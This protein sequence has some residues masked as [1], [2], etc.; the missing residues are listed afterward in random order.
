MP[1]IRKWSIVGLAKNKKLKQMTQHEIRNI[2]Q[3]HGWREESIKGHFVSR[4]QKRGPTLGIS[5]LGQ[6]RSA[7]A[8]GTTTPHGREDQR[9]A[10]YKYHWLPLLD[11]F[12]VFHP[13]R[14]RLVTIT[15]PA[16]GGKK[17]EQDLAVRPE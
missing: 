17:R 9:K 3:D 12:V 10:G 4:L 1:N 6:F 11:E 14:G 15:E 5:T 2:L 16:E 13:S 8:R 7:M